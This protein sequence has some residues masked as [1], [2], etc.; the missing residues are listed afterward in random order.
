MRSLQLNPPPPG[1]REQPERPAST[2]TYTL[3]QV[4]PQISRPDLTKTI[5][6][7][8]LACSLCSWLNGGGGVG[9]RKRKKTHTQNRA[10][11]DVSKAAAHTRQPRRR[12]E[13]AAR[14]QHQ[15]R[16]C[17]HRSAGNYDNNVFPRQL[18]SDLVSEHLPFLKSP[19]DNI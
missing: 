5:L 18:L 6:P 2:R 15:H 17:S 13:R 8:F 10:Q 12:E 7:F 9:E 19:P 1:S 14:R 11:R 3:T 16:F 4:R